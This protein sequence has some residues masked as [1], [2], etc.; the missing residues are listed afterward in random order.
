MKAKV[1][2]KL[3]ELSFVRTVEEVE[4]GPKVSTLT[5]EREIIQKMVAWAEALKWRNPDNSIVLRRIPRPAVSKLVDV[6]TEAVAAP[7]EPNSSR[8]R[9]DALTQTRA[10]FDIPSNRRQLLKVLE[11]LQLGGELDIEG[12]RA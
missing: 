1:R 11:F 5:V 6:L 8:A 7:G 12:V 3:T 4:E 9:F 10:F 2:L